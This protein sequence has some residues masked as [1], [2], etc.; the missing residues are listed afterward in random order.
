MI[1][2]A[3]LIPGFI[4]QDALEVYYDNINPLIKVRSATVFRKNGRLFLSDP[5][6]LYPINNLDT[7]VFTLIG[8]VNIINLAVADVNY[9]TNRNLRALIE[10]F[11]HY[12][13][14]E[15]LSFLH[16]SYLKKTSVTRYVKITVGK[17]RTWEGF[18]ALTNCESYIE[19]CLDEGPNSTLFSIEKLLIKM[20][21]DTP[22]ITKIIL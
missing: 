21:S 18:Y 10:Q 12:Q 1:I 4:R 13:V 20:L 17:G 6:N 9:F 15:V 5:F 3:H 14:D 7:E 19:I 16:R 11:H 2:T 22:F 8:I